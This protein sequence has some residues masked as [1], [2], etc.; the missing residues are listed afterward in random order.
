MLKILSLLFIAIT[1]IFFTAC[2]TRES[3]KPKNVV[4]D[5]EK[6]GD[7]DFNILKIAP[8]SAVIEDQKVLASGKVSNI[9]LPDGHT[10][11]GFS[12]GWIMSTNIVGDLTLQ[13]A[14]D[15]ARLYSFKLKSTIATASIQGDVLAVLFANN[16]MALYSISNKELLLKEL[17]DAPL[18]V[19]S[20]IIAPYFRDDLVLFS[21]LDGKVVIINEKRKKKLRTSIV[22]SEESFN[23]V[24]YFNLVDNKII[25]ATGN[26]VLSLSD[27]EI[28]AKYDIRGAVDDGR[29]IFLA[30]KQGEIVSLSSDLQQN[31]KIKFPFAHFLGM[32]VNNDKLYVLE[33]AGYIIEISKDLLEYS[34]Y[35][36]DVDVKDGYVLVNDKTFYVNDEYLSVE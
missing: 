1:T 11:L 29:N 17:G 18:A 33:K 35:D 19:N 31:A 13:N 9:T 27:K 5:W 26:K 4:G 22:S 25:A 3:F 32:I 6:T 10:L 36:A 23:N 15:F 28:R 14:D 12:D 7:T 2:S 24:I 20:K 16:E 8:N 34:V 21:T 30:T